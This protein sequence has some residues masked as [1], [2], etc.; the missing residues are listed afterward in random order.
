M[1]QLI[2]TCFIIKKIENILVFTITN[3]VFI[4]GPFELTA[5]FLL[6]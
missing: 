6:V 5:V 1:S 3:V 4:I 2:A